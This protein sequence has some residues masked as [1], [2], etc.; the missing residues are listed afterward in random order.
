MDRIVYNGTLAEG[1]PGG[2]SPD[3]LLSAPYLYQRIHTFAHRPLHAEA[4]IA[5]LSRALRDMHG[6]EWT[7][8]VGRLEREVAELLAANRF[9][10]RSNCVTLRLFPTGIGAVGDGPDY[11][12]EA[13]AQLFYPP[14]TLW[15]KRLSVDVFRC[16]VPFGA[17]PTALSLLA[18]R[19][20]REAAERVGAD[21][22]VLE[23]REGVLTH[24][25]GEPLFAVFG[26]QVMATPTAYGTPDTVMRKTILA[27][28]RAQGLTVAEYPLSR[29]LLERCDEA[30]T[31]SVQGIV[32]ILRYRSRHYFNTTAVKLSERLR[33]E[34]PP[35]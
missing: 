17:Y 23:T 2:I 18:A 32:S 33:R 5:I 35:R 21:T 10:M 1:W 25:D 24:I 14:Y 29:Q 4:H 26:R 22:A 13:T 16:D 11:L 34:N 3:E 8:P 27:A 9:P 12:I 28:C 7:L 30:F 15:H 19:W 6:I 20:G 31:A